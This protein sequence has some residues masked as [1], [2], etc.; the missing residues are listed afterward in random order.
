MSAYRPALRSLAAAALALAVAAS[1]SGCI[2]LFPKVKPAGLYRF[3]E[4]AP[5]AASQPAPGARIG[6]LKGPTIFTRAAAGDRLLTITG[7]EAAYVAGA[8]WVSP[9]GVLFDEAVARAFDAGGQARLIGRGEAAKADVIL[10]LE[11]RTFET[12]YVN[13]AGAPPEVVIQ[14]RAVLTRAGD[15]ALLG[16]K[17]FDARVPASVNRV[18][19]IVAA[20]DQ[21]VA[22]AL[23]DTVA[24]V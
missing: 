22:K 7:S 9:A 14:V 16:D 15:R 24:W 8:R 1:L 10:R 13:G 20:Y 3:G 5:A 4:S 11:V 17:L 19:A 21:A 2:S 23:T 6:V 18:G 12:V